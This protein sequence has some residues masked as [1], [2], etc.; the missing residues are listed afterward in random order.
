MIRVPFILC[1]FILTSINIALAQCPAPVAL[2]I[3]SVTTTESRC[4]SSGT[5]TVTA[6]GGSA[7]YTYS[8]ISGPV[9]VS[10]QSSN[11]FQSLAAGNYMLQVTDNCNISVT[12]N[13]SVTGSYAVPQVTTTPQ[14]PSCPGGNDGSIRIDVTNGRQPLLYSLI[15][16]SP[17]TAGPQ[18]GNLF[19]SLP[20]GNY[21]CRVTD[22]C[23]NFQTRAITIA[24][25]SPGN[26]A[27]ARQEMQY[28]ACDSFAIP[29]YL[30]ISASSDIKPPYTVTFTKPDNTT[31]THIINSGSNNIEDTIRFRYHRVSGSMSG[32][33]YS[34][35]VTNN[36]GAINTAIGAMNVLDMSASSTPLIGCSRQNTYTFDAYKDNSPG[37]LYQLHCSTITYTLVS[38]SGVV[39]AT[40]TNN[41]AFSGHPAGNGYKVIRED[42]CRK[43]T[44]QFDWTEVPALKINAQLLRQSDVCK[45]GTTSA[46]LLFNRNSQ[47]DIV[48]VSGPAAVTF[49]DGTVHNY[50]WP[51]TIKNI[52]FNTYG[53]SLNYFSAGTY[54]LIVTD[55]CGEKDST[56]I[57]VAPSQTRHA[58]FTAILKKGCTNANTILLNAV[59][60]GNPSP[61]FA[62]AEVTVNQIKSTPVF[63]SVYTDSVVNL[64]SGT[65]YINYT[66]NARNNPDA[67]LMN[68]ST[69]G[70]DVIKDTIVISAY[71]QPV[72]DPSAAIAVCGSTRNAALLP[73]TTRGVSPFMYQITA[74]PVT[75]PPQL[76]PV[77]ANLSPGTYTFLMS[78]ACANSYSSNITVNSLTI[79]RLVTTGNTCEGQAAT[80][81]FPASPFYNYTWQRPDGS[82]STG[83]TLSINPVTQADAGTYRITVTSALGGCTDNQ[84]N[85]YTLQLCSQ[86]VPLPLTLLNFT[87]NRQGDYQVLKWQTADEQNTSHFIVQRSTDARHFVP[88]QRVNALGGA[89]NTYPAID[90]QP[91]AGTSYYRLQMTD[92][93]GKTTYSK[94]IT[95]YNATVYR[96]DVYPRLITNE[97]HVTVTWPAATQGTFI[98]VAGIDGTILLTQPVAKGSAQT[99]IDVQKLAKGNYLIVIVNNGART[100][101]QVMK[102]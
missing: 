60:N 36:C 54:K 77:F 48:I 3:S 25:G 35:Q 44:L 91:L 96:P 87:V 58:E 79:P 11:V 18:T 9:L 51:D 28:V 4:Q 13:F 16:P 33:L 12:R 56:I 53:T 42:C 84:T 102:E 67:Y 34:I 19:N 50:T 70:C 69:Y 49:M 63:T 52:K 80:L 99:N 55:T 37:A 45:E 30:L 31:I 65:Y 22:S 93:D 57:S 61:Y 97:S 75:S 71:T 72:F 76:S 14:S 29:Y 92:T 24:D 100:A 89:H 1:F 38:P 62:D 86:V 40:Q 2:I 64:S 68:M 46:L 21:T 85:T 59:S 101:I 66:Y 94:I 15:S 88:I 17:V 74:G 23:G 82:T 5:A 90:R 32:D 78:D 81:T 26:I 20:A 39:L 47:G 83:N 73:D 43:D 98:Q 27:I 10:P 8:I 41:S 6:S 7:P 95:A